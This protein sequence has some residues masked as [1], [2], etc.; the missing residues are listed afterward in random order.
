MRYGL[1][2]YKLIKLQSNT[3]PFSEFL[4]W[5]IIWKVHNSLRE[6]LLGE[7]LSYVLGEH[8]EIGH[9]LLPHVRVFA[10]VNPKQ[11]EVVITTLKYLGTLLLFPMLQLCVQ[12]VVT[13]LYSEILHKKGHFFLDMYI[14]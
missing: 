13:I 4:I 14:K 5:F 6:I 3:R 8:K 9:R 1:P 2:T 12:E 11:K 10:R 7:G